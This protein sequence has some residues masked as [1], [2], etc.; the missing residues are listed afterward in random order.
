MVVQHSFFQQ[1]DHHISLK[2]NLNPISTSTNTTTSETDNASFDCN[3]C[4]DSACDP[5]VSLCGHL[6]C[7]PCIYKWLYAQTSKEHAHCPVCKA[8]L[9]DS[10]FVPLYG[11]GKSHSD[12]QPRSSANQEIVPRRPPPTIPNHQ[13]PPDIVQPHPNSFQNSSNLVGTTMASLVNPTIGVFGELFLTR[14]FRTSD[15]NLFSYPYRSVHPIFA[16][17]A[18]PRMRRQEMQLDKSLSR[19][20]VFLICFVIL[21]L[22]TF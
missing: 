15:P 21:C 7:W 2:Q 9:S 13:N 16:G 18:N 12:S 19:V 3:I 10:S 1:D 20:L 6:Y 4:L 5:V 17:G 22:L 14:V 8:N 11:H